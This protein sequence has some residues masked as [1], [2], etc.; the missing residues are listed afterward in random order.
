MPIWVER[1]LQIAKG[2]EPQGI[3]M[4][5]E[6]VIDLMRVLLTGFRG[7]F[8]CKGTNTWPH[9]P[10]RIHDTGSKLLKGMVGI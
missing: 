9:G 8:F 5:P 2:T 10:L 6:R 4:V 1:G 3:K 7:L